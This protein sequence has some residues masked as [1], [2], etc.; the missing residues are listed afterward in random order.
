[1]GTA[2]TVPVAAV[3]SSS[4]AVDTLLALTPGVRE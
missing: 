3:L 2:V 4:M 1:M